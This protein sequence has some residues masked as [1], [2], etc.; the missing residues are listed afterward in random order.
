MFER[1]I[2]ILGTDDFHILQNS[3]IFLIGIGGVGGYALEAL[4]RSGISSLT[5]CDYDTIEESNMNRQILA[6][7]N[8]IGA[9]KVEE[10]RNRVMSINPLCNV[11]MIQDHV[12][13]DFW[14]HYD[15][16][17]YDFVI[18]ACD[19][20]L[21]KK[22]LILR[23]MDQ[24]VPIVSCMGTGNRLHPELLEISSLD[25]TYQDPLS[26]KMR[27]LIRQ[28]DESYLRVPVVWSRECPIQ[29]DKLGTI[30][31][32]PMVA[33]SYLASYAIHTILGKKKK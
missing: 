27:Q 24:Q 6:T 3:H 12:S 32:V 7:S 2:R 20:I 10:A 13:I 22:E 11:Q 14:Q 30:C 31:T 21:V 16:S 5:I 17:G 29:T 19:D 28:V 9:Y 26:R 18:D 4:V 8:N 23:C 25:K 1:L 33:G 15:F